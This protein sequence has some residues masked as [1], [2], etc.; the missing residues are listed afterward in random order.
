MRKLLLTILLAS[1]IWSPS[2]ADELEV[3]AGFDAATDL[4]VL[5]EVLRQKDVEIK[6]I[7]TR[8]TTA[9][10]T[11]AA[12][13]GVPSGVIAIWSGSIASIPS[14]W[15]ICDGNNG[16]PNLTNMFVYGASDGSAAGNSSP[17]STS[18]GS[19]TIAGNDSAVTMKGAGSTPG[20]SGSAVGPYVIS[21]NSIMPPYY[22]L[23]YIQKT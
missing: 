3:V 7:D 16:T 13:S 19:L 9:E 20:D 14:G 21:T 11:I 4:P 12:L 1:T 18:V 2:F 8:L 10:A 5:N 17:G 15:V 22:A 23:A 6:A